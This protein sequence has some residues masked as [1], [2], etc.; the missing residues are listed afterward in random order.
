MAVSAPLS[1]EY[2][3]ALPTYRQAAELI[4]MDP[5]G[6]S[7]RIKQLNIKPVRWGN[8]EKRLRVVDLLEVA[9]GAHRNPLEAVAGELLERTGRLH[10]EQVEAIQAEIDGYFDTLPAPT[11]VPEDDFIAQLRA[12]LPPQ[13][14]EAM[15]ELYLAAQRNDQ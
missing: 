13:T 12:G 15:I 4:G 9:R 11:A 5:S 14:A 7:R 1:H 2:V 3:A 8:R 10:P 6:V